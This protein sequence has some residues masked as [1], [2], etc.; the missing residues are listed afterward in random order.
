MTSTSLLL[1]DRDTLSIVYTFVDVPFALRLTCC[2]I[3]DVF[4][5]KTQT[6]YAHVVSSIPLLTWALACGA[7]RNTGGALANA[8]ASAGNV[9]ALE[10]VY[11]HTNCELKCELCESAARGGKLTTLKWLHEQNCPWNEATATEAARG[12][13]VHILTFLHSQECP[14][15]HR[16]IDQAAERGH[17][18]CVD[19]LW[20]HNFAV[21]A[22]TY[23]C[24]AGGGQH[25][26]L[27]ALDHIYKC[28]VR[29]IAATHAA[30]GGHLDCLQH[31][32]T[33][34]HDWNARD[35]ML[36][37]AAR[38]HVALI[39]WLVVEQG[40]GVDS[41]VVNVAAENGHIQVLRLAKE[42]GACFG[43]CA[44]KN[45]AAG[46]HLGALKW[47]REN[48]C[49]WDA[50]V[51]EM[52]VRYGYVEMLEW[53]HANGCDWSE[54]VCAIAAEDGDLDTLKWLRANGCPWNEEVMERAATWGFN[55]IMTW[56]RANGCSWSTRTTLAAARCNSV[57]ALRWLI[58]EGCAYD[59]E[60]F[61]RVQNWRGNSELCDFLTQL[62]TQ[63]RKKSVVTS[64]P[65]L[66]WHTR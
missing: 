20:N 24:A 28:P 13:H 59:V 46:G 51:C 42:L 1:L 37:A 57:S 30:T 60:D 4:P 43:E 33:R 64:T 8:S 61:K 36:E 27:I 66:A 50:T 15:S 16:A 22:T 26:M 56:A 18:A 40:C 45:A 53:A 29:P 38:G 63:T 7:A 34:G 49:P 11:K 47:L 55:D 44:C 14:I 6:L 12:D 35:C 19:W 5:N 41:A 48:H 3:R 39:D 65:T 21:Y 32:V 31:I 52:A 23:E 10:H 25:S 17:Y 9:D 2:T 58:R 54:E 62:G